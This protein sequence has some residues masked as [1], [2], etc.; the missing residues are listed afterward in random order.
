MCLDLPHLPDSPFI[1]LVLLAMR[2]DGAGSG[3]VALTLHHVT[4][5]HFVTPRMPRLEPIRT[6]VLFL[7]SQAR[8]KLFTSVRAKMCVCESPPS[9]VVGPLL[10]RLD[11][12][13]E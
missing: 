5:T 9:T 6:L 4:R 13:H 3:Q 7:F 2:H 1:N 10:A 11:F 8:S 12:D